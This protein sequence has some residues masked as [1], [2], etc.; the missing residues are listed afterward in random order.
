MTVFYSIYHEIA[1]EDDYT[2]SPIWWVNSLT[3]I[4]VFLQIEAYAKLLKIDHGMID[5]NFDDF[6]ITDKNQFEKFV[7]AIIQSY[8]QQGNTSLYCEMISPFI[9]ILLVLH[10]RTT[11][12]WLTLHLPLL[13][14]INDIERRMIFNHE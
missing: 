14:N 6:W 13:Q 12:S 5:T 4:S 9:R 7:I 3:G 1:G 11:G 2:T 10:Y 8:L